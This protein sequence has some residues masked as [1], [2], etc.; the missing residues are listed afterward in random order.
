MT[1]ARKLGTFGGVFTPSILTIL[2]V[3]LFLRLPWIV[4]QAGFWTTLGI[5]LVA[6]LISVTTGLSVASIATDKRVQA[7]GTYYMISRSL[8][9]PIGGTLGLALF[10]GLSFSVSLYLIG[11]SESLLGFLGHEASVGRIRITGSLAL[12]AV[13]G[14]TLVSTALAIRTQYLI[15]AAIGLALLSVLLGTPPAMPAAPLLKPALDAAPFIV[16]FGIFFPAVTGFEAGVSMSGDLRNPKGSIPL[17]TMLAIGV[18]L[19]VYIGVAAIFAWRVP[20]A[21]LRGNP[22]VLLELSIW[23]PL[24]LAGIWGATIS[25]ALGSILGAPR[26]LQATAADGIL[27]R[28]L[29]RGHG[30]G[31]EPRNALLLTY[32]IA[33]AGILIGEL[34][35]IARVVSMFFITT[36]GFL[37]LSAAIE[38]WASPDFRPEFRVPTWIPILG[39]AT[40]FFVMLE[41]DPLAMVGATLVLGGVF[42]GV[43]RRQLQLETG[44]AWE[45]VWSALIRTALD[46]L[47]RGRRHTRNWRPNVL[48]FSGGATARPALARLGGWLVHRRGLLT[49]FTLE[50]DPSLGEGFRLL[51][52]ERLEGEDGGRGRFSRR[53][54]CG[55]LHTAMQALVR[56]YGFAGVEPNTV[57][58]GWGG[59]S[60]Q[61]EAYLGLLRAV[62][63]LDRNLL[64]LRADPRSGFGRHRRLDVWVRGEAADLGLSLA[65]LRFL[66]GAQDWQEARVRLLVVQRETLLPVETVQRRLERALAEARLEATVKVLRDPGGGRDLIDLATAESERPDLVMLPLAALGALENSADLARLEERL[67]PLPAALLVD[68][69]SSFAQA[70]GG[71]LPATLPEEAPPAPDL[72]GEGTPLELPADSRLASLGAR[73]TLQLDDLAAELLARFVDPALAPALAPREPLAETVERTLSALQ[74]ALE[75]EVSESARRRS[76]ARLQAD[77]L[78]QAS[79]RLDAYGAGAPDTQRKRLQEGFEWLRGRLEGLILSQP[80]RLLDEEGTTGS[81]RRG[82]PLRRL[83]R[84]QLEASAWL[85]QTQLLEQLALSAFREVQESQALL[86]RCL[87][88]LALVER[89]Y[90][91]QARSAQTVLQREV[92]ELEQALARLRGGS[93]ASR[94]TAEQAWREGWRRLEQE[95]LDRM[96]LRPVPPLPGTAERGQRQ[97]AAE[98]SLPRWFEGQERLLALL[99]LD[100]RLLSIRS[101]L[102]IAVGR[103]RQAPLQALKAVR[104]GRLGDLLEALDRVL[105]G[106]AALEQLRL[107]FDTEP[108]LDADALVDELLGEIGR[109]CDELPEKAEVAGEEFWQAIAEGQLVEA[110]AASL[111]LKRLVASRL[112]NLFVDPF[113]QDLADWMRRTREA[114]T[115]I[116]DAVRL[117]LFQARVDTADHEEELDERLATLQ[118]CRQR[119]AD[120]ADLLE[121][122]ELE[123]GARL[124]HHLDRAFEQLNPF[125][126]SRSGGELQ[127]FLR[128]A[129]TRE[130]LGLATRA[131]DGLRGLATDLVYR[132]SEA[133]T[134]AWRGLPRSERPGRSSAPLLAALEAREP[135]PGVLE[136]LPFAYRQLFL[137]RPTMSRDFWNGREG[138]LA[139]ADEAVQ[140]WRGGRPG[141]LLVCGEPG[142]GKSAFCQMLALRHGERGRIWSVAAPEAASGDPERLGRRLGEV[143]GLAGSFEEQLARL[144]D[145]GLLLLHDLSLWWQRREG[146]LAALETLITALEREGGRLLLVLSGDR[147]ALALIQRLL[148]LEGRLLAR[149]DLAPSSAR[150]IGGVV[151]QRHRSTGLELQLDGRSEHPR[152][153]GERSLSELQ[154]ARAFARLFERSRGNLGEALRLWVADLAA[155]DGRSLE[156]RSRPQAAPLEMDSLSAAARLPLLQLLL[157]RRLEPGDLLRLCGVRPGHR[158]QVT[159]ELERL[160]RAAWIT[161]GQAALEINPWLQLELLRAFE[162]R[163]LL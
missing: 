16:L 31:G 21:E 140:R 20:A 101:R 32:L 106:Q 48:L 115:E 108:P 150:S 3:I 145:G 81:R 73:L 146:G 72:P 33:Q 103:R 110:Q 98:Q 70:F 14:V 136:T 45:G 114:Y 56:V 53:V 39:A 25:S 129:R 44:D 17:G 143:T 128:T 79:R 138:E 132:R 63:S 46:R 144:P 124:D 82:L 89:A 131:A 122:L 66:T 15:M 24:V 6:H 57:L 118:D 157:H 119:I 4:G 13:A 69:D 133:L 37:N 54:R 109:I 71:L 86:R 65:L 62:R 90:G 35:L 142:A 123:L 92:A 112:E 40:A 156:L 7:G 55:E 5:I 67:S 30:P 130:A 29:A 74:K 61:P 47:L 135:R 126:L 52:P 94:V 107:G 28:W 85:L 163:S 19:A 10:V 22:A 134:L 84:E 97:E 27:P 78:F 127:P 83:L 116:G 60:G 158:C 11:F 23:P 91:E 95:L 120:R 147:H 75:G 2:G 34:D 151:L 77:L 76:L 80:E 104:D 105:A 137:G 36:Y 9:L 162:E 141:A 26:I 59:R 42:L 155:C 68:G 41:L 64:L 159:V 99:R 160:Q 121:A 96:A 100:L 125:E 58:L 8:G 43:K 111:A 51:P 102:R 18:G 38:S 117:A 1:R 88:A 154:L 153:L 149:V 139:Q 113:E 12:A 161:G 93:G 49:D 87:E 50:H 152:R 148:D